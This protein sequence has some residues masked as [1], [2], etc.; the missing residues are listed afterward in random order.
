MSQALLTGRLKLTLRGNRVLLNDLRRDPAESE[1]LA[2]RFPK[3]T[4]A[5]RRELDRQL[6]STAA[7]AGE[8]M[9]LDDALRRELKA[10]GYL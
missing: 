3:Q 4:A 2:D 8:P 6:S 10:L 1:N 7:V 5:L 9:T